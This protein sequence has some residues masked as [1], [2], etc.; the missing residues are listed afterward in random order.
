MLNYV[1][2]NLSL[3]NRYRIQIC[4]DSCPNDLWECIVSVNFWKCIKCVDMDTLFA[5]MF[6]LFKG[7]WSD[8]ILYNFVAILTGMQLQ[9]CWGPWPIGQNETAPIRNFCRLTMFENEFLIK[10]KQFVLTCWHKLVANVWLCYLL[11]VLCTFIYYL[12]HHII[13]ATVLRNL[14]SDITC[15]ARIGLFLS[16]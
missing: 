15:T 9:V 16:Y 10:W 13:W 7:A 2:T 5:E 1:A 6:K 8:L 3:M 11:P 12:K 4:A 14:T